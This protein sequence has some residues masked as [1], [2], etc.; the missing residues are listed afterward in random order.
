MGTVGS[1]MGLNTKS[2]TWLA[3]MFQ[4][5]F[6]SD[7]TSTRQS[8]RR[9][10]LQALG[11]VDADGNPVTKDP[12]EFLKIVAAHASSMSPEER[13]RDF[14]AG[15][16][17]QGARGAAIFTDPAVM[18]NLLGLTAGLRS[19]ATPD[20]LKKQYSNSPTVKFDKELAEIMKSLTTL[21]EDILPAVNVGIKGLDLALKAVML[22]LKVTWSFIRLPVTAYEG[23]SSLFNGTSVAP[24]SS[25]QRSVV[26]NH[27]TALDGRVLAKSTTEYQIQGLAQAPSSGTGFDG[28]LS[29]APVN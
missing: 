22:S 10:A 12:M 9:T 28:R 23:I 1:Q 20:Q 8:A 25:S 3:Q 6:V 29:L 11:I 4:A 26:L 2:G 15:F 5:P 19:A 24:P 16:G 17:Q 18:T 7:L 13:M 27:T 14:V 21:G